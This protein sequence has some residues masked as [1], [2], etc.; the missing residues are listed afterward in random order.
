MSDQHTTTA[1]PKVF[2]DRF[3]NAI[4]RAGNRLPQPFNLFLYLFLLVGVISTALAWADV[5]VTVPGS[6]EPIA[7]QGLSPAPAW[8]GSPRTSARTSSSSRPWSRW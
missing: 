1:E 7:I 6:D 2:G 3:L 5:S 4:E 8:P